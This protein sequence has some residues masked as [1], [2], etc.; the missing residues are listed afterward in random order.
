MNRKQ[1]D[2]MLEEIAMLEAKHAAMVNRV[3]NVVIKNLTIPDEDFTEEVMRS[4][5]LDAM[6]N[7]V[8]EALKDV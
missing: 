3:K 2:A 6:G 1:V 8:M 5:G 7:A 4:E